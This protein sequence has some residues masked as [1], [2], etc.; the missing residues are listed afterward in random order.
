[1][2]DK[3]YGFKVGEEFYEKAKLVI[4]ASGL[5]SKE[6]FERAVA[7]YETNAIKEGS[8]DYKQDLTE[9]E[10]HTTRMY[11]LIVNMIQRSVYLKE[12]AVKEVSDQL[13]NKEN[14]ITNLQQQLQ[15]TKDALKA[16]VLLVQE[17]SNTVVELEDQLA[18]N[19]IILNNNQALIEEYKDKNDT[20][21]GFVVKYKEYADENERIKLDFTRKSKLYEEQFSNE[22]SVLLQ[23]V[24]TIEEQITSITSELASTQVELKQTK[25]NH[26]QEMEFVVEQKK[27]EKAQALVEEKANHNEEVRKLYDEIESLRKTQ[28]TMNEQLQ[29]EIMQ[30]R[31][32][33]K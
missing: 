14:L 4:E 25:L 23:Q 8:S 33:K 9:L 22:K 28:Q 11:E 27:L 31:E 15:T 20:L 32:N 19:Q 2:A 24:K 6:W 18:K 26:Q 29:N 3:T 13:Q 17:H 16:N 1:M 10:H 12:H 5:T 7:L 30:L 21:N